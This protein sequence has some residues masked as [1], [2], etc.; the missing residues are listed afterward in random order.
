MNGFL[1]C[2]Q[3]LQSISLQEKKEKKKDATTQTEH[4]PELVKLKKAEEMK[5]EC[6]C[7]LQFN[8]RFKSSQRIFVVFR[9][10]WFLLP[11][12]SC[13]FYKPSVRL[14]HI[15]LKKKKNKLSG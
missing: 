2:V 1:W 15:L 14:G 5:R 12:V 4:Q 6:L 11:L 8:R 9:Q 3:E 10:V 7:Q 13:C